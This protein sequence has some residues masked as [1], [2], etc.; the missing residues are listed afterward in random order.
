LVKLLYSILGNE[1]CRD[2][3]TLVLETGCFDIRKT[4]R[5]AKTCRSWQFV[6]PQRL[7]RED[8]LSPYDHH[9]QASSNGKNHS[10][11]RDRLFLCNSETCLPGTRCD[12]G[13][14]GPV[15]KH[16][17]TQ[18]PSKRR[19]LLCTGHTVSQHCAR[20]SMAPSSATIGL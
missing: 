15:A 3:S 6:D 19:R 7:R 20:T 5:L 4:S 8:I 1:T 18:G 11:L 17:I 2:S 13:S 12:L 16:V 10:G 14:Q 9:N